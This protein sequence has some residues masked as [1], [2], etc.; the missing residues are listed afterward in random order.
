MKPKITITYKDE[1]GLNDAINE[2]I[3]QLAKSV[4]EHNEKA[5]ARIL[6]EKA[7]PPIKGEI[8]KG[9]IKW[10]GIILKEKRDMQEYKI[11]VWQREKKIGEILQ[12][13]M[14]LDDKL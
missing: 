12:G 3:N 5:L 8:T 9:K 13:Y 2:S 4:E 11:E 7:Y 6:R 1:F 14:I 10:R